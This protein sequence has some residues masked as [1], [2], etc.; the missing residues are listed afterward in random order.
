MNLLTPSQA[1]ENYFA[2]WNAP[3]VDDCSAKL[4]AGC[5]QDVVVLHPE[6]ER[7]LNGWAAVASH[8]AYFRER[9]GH[10]M[11]PTSRIDAHHR[12]CRVSWRLAD[13]ADVLSTGVLVADAAGDGRLQRVI[14]FIDAPAVA[15]APN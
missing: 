2:A 12:V 4:L 7:P 9:H 8:V 10:R 14:H 13:G 5:A 1:L 3:H 11:E 6:A 15:P